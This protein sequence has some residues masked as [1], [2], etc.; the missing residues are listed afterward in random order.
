MEWVLLDAH[1]ALLQGLMLA[2]PGTERQTSVAKRC[3]AL[4]A[5]IRLTAIAPCRELLDMQEKVRPS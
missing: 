5:L 3:Q 2:K 4:A 1:F